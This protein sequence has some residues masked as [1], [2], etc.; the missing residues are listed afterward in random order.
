MYSLS[1]PDTLE[2]KRQARNRII[3]SAKKLLTTDLEVGELKSLE[4]FLL[5]KDLF[6]V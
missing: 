5:F 4:N 1:L 3:N 2:T 6:C